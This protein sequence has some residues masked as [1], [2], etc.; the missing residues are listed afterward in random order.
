[1][2]LSYPTSEFA[3]PAALVAPGV[4]C[5]RVVELSLQLAWFI[6]AFEVTDREDSGIATICFAWDTDLVTF[7]GTAEHG[8][9]RSLT[10]MVPPWQAT[11]GNWEAKSIAA[12]HREVGAEDHDGY[13]FEALDGAHIT[14]TGGR[15]DARPGRLELVAR[16]GCVAR[17]GNPS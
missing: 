4:R 12:I 11:S 8:Q 2:F 15:E 7:M 1:M 5:W 9:L 14:M 17:E 13:V 16:I 10:C 3:V 6:A